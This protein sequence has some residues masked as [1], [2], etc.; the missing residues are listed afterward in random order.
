MGIDGEIIGKIVTGTLTALVTLGVCL[1]NNAVQLKR[2]R[3][4]REQQANEQLKALKDD[5]SKQINEI[6]ADFMA[7]MQELIATQQDIN[8]SIALFSYKLQDLEK[9]IEKHN[10]VVDRTYALE[11]DMD[12]AKEQYAMTNKRLVSL[13]EE[14]KKKD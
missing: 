14:S 8:N 11:R 2:D 7:H 3:E 5:M 10:Q 12:V 1:I 13:E 6:R 4:A 9:R